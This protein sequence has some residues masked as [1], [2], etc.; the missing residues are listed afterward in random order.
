MKYMM[1]IAGSEET[2]ATRTDEENAALYDRIRGWWSE[3]T[4][5]G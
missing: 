3:Q 1:M 5:S 2:W 4:A